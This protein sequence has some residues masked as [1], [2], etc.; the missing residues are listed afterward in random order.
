M[1]ACCVLIEVLTSVKNMQFLAKTEIKYWQHL[2]MQHRRQNDNLYCDTYSV[3]QIYL[4]I[5]RVEYAVVR[6]II[7][8]LLG[9]KPNLK[10][11]ASSET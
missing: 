1:V 2:Q 9:E 7:V 6:R 10:F 11:N 8:V 4:F 5:T 3:Y